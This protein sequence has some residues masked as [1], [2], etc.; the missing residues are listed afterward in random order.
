MHASCQL[1]SSATP[2]ACDLVLQAGCAAGSSCTSAGA[3]E[4][5]LGSA[6]LCQ[7]ITFP[8]AGP[9]LQDCPLV[10]DMGQLC[11]LMVICMSALHLQ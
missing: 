6:A 4:R 9:A 2:A 1:Q 7:A 3:Q 5:H 8:A 10:P 11:A